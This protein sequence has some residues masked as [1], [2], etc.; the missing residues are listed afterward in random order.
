MVRIL[1]NCL[2]HEERFD[3]NYSTLQDLKDALVEKFKKYLIKN[4]VTNI[5]VNP[6]LTYMDKSENATSEPQEK[7]LEDI[8]TIRNRGDEWFEL[9]VKRVDIITTIDI[10][11]NIDVLST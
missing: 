10:N 2:G 3:G 4:N 7:L 11:D 9:S 1:A 8:N 5:N 6:L